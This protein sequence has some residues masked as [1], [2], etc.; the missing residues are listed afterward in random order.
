MLISKLKEQLKKIPANPGI[1]LFRDSNNKPLYIGKALNLKKRVSNY[2]RNEDIRL[3]RML[4][5]AEKIDF[6]ETNSD[7]EALILE[8]RYIKKYRPD[9]NIRLRDDKQFSFV[10]FTHS[11]SSGQAEKYPKIFI[12]HQPQIHEEVIGP[13]TDAGALKTTLNLLRR[14]F[15]YCT[16]KQLHHN[17]CLNYHIEKC[18]GI[19][20]LKQRDVMTNDKLPMTNEYRKNI[21][22]IKDILSGKKSSL[23]KNLE[24][25][26]RALSDR[27]EFEKAQ[28]LQ[29]KI[30]RLKRVFQNA[31]II[32]NSKFI[33]QNSK[34]EK[35]NKN[36]LKQ[37]AKII[38]MDCL[39]HRIEAYD[40]ANIQ[41]KYAVGAM[42]VFT[43]GKPDKNQYRKFKI[44]TKHT[45]DLPDRQAGDTAMLREILT[46]RFN[47]PEWPY[48]DLIVIDGGKGQLNTAKKTIY[49]SSTSIEVV[50]V[51][52]NEKHIGHKITMENK[53]IL[54]SKLP[55]SV[56]NLLL[57]INS[58]AHRF[59]INYY[60]KLHQKK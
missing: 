47:H 51:T 41:G 23:I 48:P 11:T 2:L 56:K 44:Y 19:C 16:C 46:R 35:E 26:M 3:T 42:A 30:A 52:K 58:E 53:E 60:R 13:F 1:Y 59:A 28:D 49:R 20:C 10:L 32:H 7:I 29:Y 37:L 57:Q 6:I 39:P 36:I 21:K 33:I 8:S 22:A 55:T 54:L 50:A 34:T 40:I 27:Q 12:T 18:I 15:P 38:G 31:N 4:A 9:F 45:P 14:I 43:D 25:E 5:G 17:Y 24:K